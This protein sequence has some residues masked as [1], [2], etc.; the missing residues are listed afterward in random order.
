M[1]QS[2]LEKNKKTKKE[3]TR[4]T[5]RCRDTH[6]KIHKFYKNIKLVPLVD[7][8]KTCMVINKYQKQ[9]QNKKQSQKSIMRSSQNKPNQS[10][11]NTTELVL[12]WLSVAGHGSCSQVYSLECT[13][14]E[15]PLEKIFYL[16][17]VIIW[18]SL[19][20]WLGMWTCVCFHSQ[21][22][23][24]HQ[25]QTWAGHVHAATV[26]VNSHVHG[27][28]CISKALPLVI[29]HALFFLSLALQGSLN[30]GRIDR[31][32]PFGTECSKV[33]WLSAQFS[34]RVLCIYSHDFIWKLLWWWPSVVLWMIMAPVGS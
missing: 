31:D 18:R 14:S 34:A 10:L 27:S 9:Q 23:E 13:P 26:C 30:L 5:H 25:G 12:H 6:W 20:G 24:N 32:M 3:S 7:K 17:L 29:F 1:K 4:N 22:R 2:N 8:Q 28:F 33:L 15:T 19:P 11:Q 16:L 21:H